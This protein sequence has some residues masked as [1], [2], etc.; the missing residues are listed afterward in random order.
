MDA[1]RTDRRERPREN[2]PDRRGRRSEPRV[3]L[4]LPASAE[5]ISGY[6]SIRLLD[7]SVTG[8]RLEGRDLPAAGR[9]IVLRCGPMDAF[10]TIAWTANNRCGMQFDEPLSRGDLMALRQLADAEADCGMTTEERQ[11]AADW[12]NGLAR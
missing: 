6:R 5:A 11:A 7:V 4:V 12:L 10:G 9:D 3:C 2:D 1:I 8:A